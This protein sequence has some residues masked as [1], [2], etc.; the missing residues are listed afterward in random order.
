MAADKYLL[1]HFGEALFDYVKAKL[2]AETSCLIYDQLMKIGERE[3]ISLADVRT[4]IIENSKA[5]IESEHFTKIDQETLIGL[6]SLDELTVDEDE[7]LAAVSKWVDCEVQRQ[8][9][10]ADSE[11]LRKVFEPIKGY[12]VFTALTPEK[13]ANCKKIAKILTWEEVGSLFLHLLN[14]ENPWTIELKSPRNAGSS[15]NRYTVFV[16]DLFDPEARYRYLREV[17]LRVSRRVRIL[18]IYSTYSEK[19]LGASLQILD[20]NGV[21]LGSKIERLAKD[22][23]LCF[24]VNPPLDVQPNCSYTLKVTG[25]GQ[26]TSADELSAQK[27]FNFKG[28]EFDLDYSGFIYPYK[29]HCIRG[30]E[31]SRFV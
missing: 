6:L 30:L 2:N 18:T 19:V 11:N 23:K 10:P 13:I 5:T 3:E 20:S 7:L 14:K 28:F 24:S 27:N 4:M 16:S 17:H 15:L 22:G 26:T 1:H 25:D 31:F 8:G 9:L 29:A 12:I 21:D